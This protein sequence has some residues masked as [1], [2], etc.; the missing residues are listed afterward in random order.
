M[1]GLEMHTQHHSG[2]YI[3]KGLSIDHTKFILHAWNALNEPPLPEAEIIY[4]VES[5]K[6]TH[7][8][9]KINAPLFQ[10]TREHIAPPKDLFNPPGML[11][12]MYK[13]CEEIAQISQPELSIVGALAL[14][15]VSC[16]RLYRTTMNN[17]V[18]IFYDAKSGQGKENIKSF[19]ETVLNVR[20][21][22]LSSVGY[23]SSV[24]SIQYY[25]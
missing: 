7:D 4:T 18:I 10:T 21:S 24:L 22:I 9:K 8:R 23:T 17:F 3:S 16:G 15:S 2:Y 13:F 14:A 6:K 25:V 5:V 20:H 11:K 12:D 1:E 19:V